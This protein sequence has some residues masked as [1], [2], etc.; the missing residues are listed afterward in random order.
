MERGRYTAGLFVELYMHLVTGLFCFGQGR[1]AALHGQWLG[2]WAHEAHLSWLSAQS[3]SL[4]TRA[5]P[6]ISE[7]VQRALENFSESQILV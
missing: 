3:R 4:F 6:L 7:S 1:E 5:I 2:H